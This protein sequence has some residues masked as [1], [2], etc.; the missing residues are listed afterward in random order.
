M[1]IFVRGAACIS[2]QDTFRAKEFL[3]GIQRYDQG[4]LTCIEPYYKDF[5]PVKTLRRM[6]RNIKIAVVSALECLDMAGIEM[7]D[8]ISTGTGLGCVENTEKFLS[9]VLDDEEQLISP[10]PFMHSTHNTIGS[11]IAILLGCN[12]YNVTHAHKNLAF[13][14]A[15]VD[16]TMLI[17]EREA[18]NVLVGGAD[19]ITHEHF[20]LKKRINMWKKPPNNNIDLMKYTSGGTIP[21]EGAAFFLIS[22]HQDKRDYARI[23]FVSSIYNPG[24]NEAIEGHILQVIKEAGLR[25]VDLDLV[26]LG[27]NGDADYDSIY[28]YLTENLFNAQVV[29]C[30]KHLCGEYDTSSA[31]AFWTAINILKIQEIPP[32]MRLNQCKRK[33][34]KN[35]LIYNQ[36]YNRNHSFMLLSKA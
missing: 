29:A 28:Y 34:I 16:S 31:F 2:P 36:N 21:G 12:N 4:Y 1:E 7:P 26:I 27:N 30:F 6:S 18:E 8:A 24:D 32:I 10:T 13:E 3:T 33:V 5:L 11:Q 19:E 20:D 22:G 9:P 25:L 35:I 14:D 23:L 17:R 15:L